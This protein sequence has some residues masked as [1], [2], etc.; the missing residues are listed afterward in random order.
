VPPEPVAVNVTEV[1]TVPLVGPLIVTE[2]GPAGA[3]VIVADAVAVAAFAEVTI[4]ET[5]FVPLTGYVVVKLA[6]VPLAGDPPVAV[7]EKV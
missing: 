4:T 5:V 1:P 6:P 7:Q 2:N 3:M